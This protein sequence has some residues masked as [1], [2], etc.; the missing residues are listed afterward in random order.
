M[1]QHRAAESC[2]PISVGYM[3]SFI[4]PTHVS[5]EPGGIHDHPFFSM[6]MYLRSLM[7]YMTI[8][9]SSCSCIPGT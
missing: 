2:I 3:I 7:G 1:T 9:F 4:H 5:Q 8:L 6:L